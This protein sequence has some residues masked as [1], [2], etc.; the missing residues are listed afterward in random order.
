MHKVEGCLI[1]HIATKSQVFCLI[2]ALIP[3]IL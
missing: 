1:T 2:I 3:G